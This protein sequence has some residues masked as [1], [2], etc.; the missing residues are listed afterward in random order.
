MINPRT[1]TFPQRASLEDLQRI[2]EINLQ[3]IYRSWS[4]ALESANEGDDEDYSFGSELRR[5]WKNYGYLLTNNV[6][7][8]PIPLDLTSAV[9]SGEKLP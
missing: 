6:V 5:R 8:E 2:A 9:K 3:V 1:A 7:S 4:V